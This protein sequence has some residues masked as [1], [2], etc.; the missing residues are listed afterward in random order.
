[1]LAKYAVQTPSTPVILKLAD[2]LKTR[3]GEKA[4]SLFIADYMKAHPSVRGLDR[5]IDM[6]IASAEG[7]TREHFDVLQRLTRQLLAE[8]PVYRCSDCGFDAQHLH[9][10][11]PT[12]KHWGTLSPQQEQEQH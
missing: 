7:S 12:C 6:N 11:C 3:Y 2:R 5:I 1:M 8:Q 9:W 4:A 10:Q